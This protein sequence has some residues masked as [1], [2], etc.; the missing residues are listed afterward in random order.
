MLH[1]GQIFPVYSQHSF[2]VAYAAYIGHME[3]LRHKWRNKQYKRAA[4][5][6]VKMNII[7]LSIELF[8]M[9]F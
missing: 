8:R 7:I 2:F 5:E 6:R 4:I 9:E 1:A 3:G